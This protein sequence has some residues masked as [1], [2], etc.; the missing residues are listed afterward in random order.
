M[1]L[2]IVTEPKTLDQAKR[3]RVA[4]VRKQ[5]ARLALAGFTYNG[6]TFSLSTNDRNLILGQQVALA[7]GALPLPVTWQTLD[8][9]D[10]ET[11][12]T[13][14]EA[15]AFFGAAVT[16]VSQI[17]QAAIP[18]FD[19]IGKTATIAEALAVQDTRT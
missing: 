12:N 18:I 14:G 17:F 11:L 16:R 10:S 8:G 9:L 19:A 6:K 7:G 15:T 5:S 13:A 4:Q 3:V 1:G 2:D